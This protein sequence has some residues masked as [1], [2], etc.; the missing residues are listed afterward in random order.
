MP[1][2]GAKKH[3]RQKFVRLYSVVIE[4]LWVKRLFLTKIR[5]KPPSKNGGCPL[6]YSVV[7]FAKRR[8]VIRLSTSGVPCTLDQWIAGMGIDLPATFGLTFS[9]CFNLR[10]LNS[11]QI[12]NLQRNASETHY[13]GRR[14]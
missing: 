14:S 1:K 6:G 7:C 10:G 5:E 8:L 3:R 2:Y 12:N 9:G 13:R 4:G 11:M